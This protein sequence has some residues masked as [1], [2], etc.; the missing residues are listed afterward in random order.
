MLI[1]ENVLLEPIGMKYQHTTKDG[2]YE[3]VNI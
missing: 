3:I 1:T 2:T